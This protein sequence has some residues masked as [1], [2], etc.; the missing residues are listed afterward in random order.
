MSLAQ[1][2]KEQAR[3][4][5]AALADAEKLRK[6]A[7][8]HLERVIK[9]FG[10]VKSSRRSLAEQ[11]KSELFELRHLAIGK[12]A[13]D[14]S[15]QDLDGKPFKLSDYLGKVVVLDFWGHW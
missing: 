13:P 1:Y 14:I 9:D 6:E 15:G 7:E 12:K 4:P 10:E 5:Q 3:N 8:T 11:A 2:L